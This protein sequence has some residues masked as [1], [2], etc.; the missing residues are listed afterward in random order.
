[1]SCRAS[2]KLAA[3]PGYSR[4][5]QSPVRALPDTAGSERAVHME[6]LKVIGTEND[7]LVLATES[8]ERFSLAIDE[9]LRAEVR[10]ARRGRDGDERTA[11][12]PSPREVQA[13]IRAG[14]SAEE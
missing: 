6:Q 9:V 5:T 2:V 3:R 7:R 4:R 1:M 10:R 8:G 11:A 13:H 14:L 12:R